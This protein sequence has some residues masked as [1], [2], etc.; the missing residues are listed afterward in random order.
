MSRNWVLAIFATC[1]LFMLMGPSRTALAADAAQGPSF[2]VSGF[3]GLTLLSDADLYQSGVGSDRFSYDAGGGVG[4]SVGY[5]W[6]F[7]LR[8]E[9]EFSY[10]SN[11]VNTIDG[12]SVSGA[13]TSSLAFL[14]NG[15]Y[16][17]NLGSGL[18]P[19]V[20]GGLGVANVKLNLA[21]TEYDDTVFA[22]QLGGGLGY[23]I[24]PGI[25]LFTDYRWL[26]TED[27]VILQTAPSDI[28]LEYSSHSIMFGARAHF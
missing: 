12:F 17:F 18:L 6:P 2:Y 1:M 4:A 8:T 28:K 9:F 19:Y 11:D 25:V 23:Q 10:R 27:A 16:D 26:A 15:W 20:G 7:G 3:G 21:G 24:M 14:G 5:R 13:D 22:W